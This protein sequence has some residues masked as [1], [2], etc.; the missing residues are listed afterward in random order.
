METGGKLCYELPSEVKYAVVLLFTGSIDVDD[1]EK[2]VSISNLV[3]GTKTGLAG[4]SRSCAEVELLRKAEPDGSDFQVVTIESTESI[5]KTYQ[6]I[7][8]GYDSQG[9]LTHASPPWQVTINWI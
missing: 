1:D 3:G 7:V 4:F 9:M 2:T 8:L 6:W 5:S